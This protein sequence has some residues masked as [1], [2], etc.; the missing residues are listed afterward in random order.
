MF[1]A[2]LCN[3]KAFVE[4]TAFGKTFSFRMEDIDSILEPLRLSV[5]EQGDVVR[6]LKTQKAPE[7]DIK[8]AVAELKKRKKALQDK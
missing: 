7:L 3:E 2:V 5:K 4:K 8:S 1:F 6:E